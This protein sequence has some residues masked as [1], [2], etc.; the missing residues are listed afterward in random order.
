MEVRKS[1]IALVFGNCVNAL[2]KFII[3]CFLEGHFMRNFSSSYS[4]SIHVWVAKDVTVEDI[5]K[6]SASIC[7]G[8][9]SLSLTRVIKNSKTK[10]VF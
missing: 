8:I 6:L 1:I 2:G 5:P 4:K 10:S 7:S 9:F 3:I